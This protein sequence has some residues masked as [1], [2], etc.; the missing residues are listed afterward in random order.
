MNNNLTH[1]KPVK[2]TPQKMEKSKNEKKVESISQSLICN[3]KSYTSSLFEVNRE[4]MSWNRAT[5]WIKDH[6]A[7]RLSTGVIWGER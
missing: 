7:E 3:L 1:I 5:E 6:K 4:I 2:K